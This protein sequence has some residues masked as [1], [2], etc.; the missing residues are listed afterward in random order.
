MKLTDS[1]KKLIRSLLTGFSV[2]EADVVGRGLPAAKQAARN[3]KHAE[4]LKAKLV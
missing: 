4:R 1:D 2:R 3:V